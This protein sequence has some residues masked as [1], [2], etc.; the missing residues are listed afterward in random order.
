MASKGTPFPAR[1]SDLINQFA[2]EAYVPEIHL[3][4]DF[5][6]KIDAPRM[7][8]A[9][10]LLLDAEPVLGCR[11]VETWRKAH[12]QPL[13]QD[14]L[15]RADILRVVSASDAAKESAMQDFLGDL[16]DASVG[17]QLKGLLLASR[18]KRPPGSENQS[19]DLRCRRFQG[20]VVPAIGHLP[21]SFRRC[22]TT[23]RRFDR[24]RAASGRF[25]GASRSFRKWAS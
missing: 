24:A 21:S 14:E 7:K 22:G 13:A 4:I 12:W 17:P 2:A 16:M 6:G 1:H 15:E 25:T 23:G 18:A 11:F 9:I 8:K 3:I 19:H 20:D 10:R 5:D